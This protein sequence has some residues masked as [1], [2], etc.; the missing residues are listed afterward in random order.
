[1]AGGGIF[2]QIRNKSYK[3]KCAPQW[4]LAFSGFLGDEGELLLMHVCLHAQA[5]STAADL[6]RTLNNTCFPKLRGITGWGLLFPF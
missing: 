3:R 4:L 2:C 6:P 5:F 1:M